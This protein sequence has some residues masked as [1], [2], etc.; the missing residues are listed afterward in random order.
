MCLFTGYAPGKTDLLVYTDRSASPAAMEFDYSVLEGYTIY[1]TLSCEN[2]AGLTYSLSTD[3]VKISNTP[4]SISTVQMEVLSLSSTEYNPRD[5]YLGLTD[6]MR[7][8]WSGFTDSIGVETYKVMS[9]DCQGS[10]K[11]GGYIFKY[12]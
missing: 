11:V 2:N 3:G 9:C 10:Y 8:K 7:I 1:T 5:W 6:T 4:P 12:C